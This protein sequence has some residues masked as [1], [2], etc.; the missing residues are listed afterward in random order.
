MQ[1]NAKGN[2]AK[3]IANKANLKPRG[4]EEKEKVT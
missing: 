2:M 4:S 1:L 3:A